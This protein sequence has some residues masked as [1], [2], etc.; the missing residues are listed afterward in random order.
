MKYLLFIAFIFI[1]TSASFAQNDS[2][3]QTL[4]EVIIKENRME[5]PFSKSSRNISIIHRKDIET[6]P[7]RSLQE[8]LSFTPGLDVRQRGVSGVQADIGIRGGSF[9]QTLMLVNG[10]KLSDPQTGHH[11]VNIPVPLASVQ[12]IDILK[13][14]ASRIY[15]QNAYA[16]AINIITE[17]P[18]S[19]NLQAGLYGGDFGMRG[20]S[21]Q[22]S[23]PIGKFK[24][25]LA[26]SHNASDG[27]WH[28]SDYSINTIF[29]EAGFD[30]NAFQEI[31]TILSFANRDFG[32]N[33]FYSSSFPDQWE[34][35]QTGLAAISHTLE[36]GNTYVQS[37]A[38]WRSNKD[39]FLLK[40][41]DPSFFQNQH[42]TNVYALEINGRQETNFGT[43]GFGV[44]GRQEK[45]TAII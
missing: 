34:S 14:P 39:E 41:N 4:N 36:K 21:F 44:E 1:A 25:S 29:Y 27:H 16:G 5:I 20:G 6:A 26:V 11:M 10:I 30:V 24:Q 18:E 37:R 43:L 45:L 3:I 22:V 35:I 7:A 40:R 42:T 38:Y 31:K 19:F 8:I 9:E 23:L 32:A 17:L 15:G 33:G 2:T 13:G 28:N 12:R